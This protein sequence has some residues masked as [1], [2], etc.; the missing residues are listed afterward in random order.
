MSFADDK[1][2]LTLNGETVL[3]ATSWSI[4]QSVLQQPGSFEVRLGRGSV[5]PDPRLGPTVKDLIAK[6]PPNTPFE[7]RIN[8]CLRMKGRTDGYRANAAGGQA[9][10]LTIFGRDTLAPLHDAHIYKEMSFNDATYSSLVKSVLK[11]VGLDPNKL[12]TSG[13]NVDR[14]LKSGVPVRELL[15]VRII[16]EILAGKF[17]DGSGIGGTSGSGGTT[18]AGASHSVLQTKAGERWMDY[19]RKQLDRAGLFLWAGGDGSIILSAPH[20]E[21]G[22]IYRI[23]RRR[24]QNR[25]QVNVIHADLMNDTRPRYSFGIVY[26]RGGGKKKGRT[27]SIGDAVDNE[28]LDVYGFG[29][30]DRGN[31]SYS[32]AIVLRDTHCQNAAQAAFLAQRKLA[33]GRRHGW[34]LVYTM[35]GLSTPALGGG[36]AVWTPD[37]VVSVQDDEFGIDSN[38]WIESVEFGRHP[39]SYTTIRLMRSTDVIFGTAEFGGGNV[40]V[41]TGFPGPNDLKEVNGNVLTPRD[42]LALASAF[43]AGNASSATDKKN[44]P[45]R[46]QFLKALAEYTAAKK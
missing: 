23:V 32:R 42:K 33:E 40:G 26:G 28:M 8:D 34:Q 39:Q 7:L 44:T 31:P 14:K 11:E 2:S 22:P 18:T 37:T 10:E 12:T 30:D 25:N 6:Y 38:Y 24:G 36:R 20:A 15:P 41:R 16:D 46:T 27:K 45:S 43:G 29:K 17:E 3:L 21:L 9:T 35:A 5:N 19:L 13:A 1:V 4:K